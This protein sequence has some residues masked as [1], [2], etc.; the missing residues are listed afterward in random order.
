MT[1][2]ASLCLLALGLIVPVVR[3]EPVYVIEQLVVSVSSDPGGEG[4]NIGQV[5][6]A[7][8]L[9][10]LERQGEESHVRLPSGKEGWVKSSYL[11]SDEPLQGR[12]NERTSELEKAKQEAEKLRQDVSHLQAEV[13]SANA[14]AAAAT[15]AA[16]TKP[17]SPPAAPATAQPS[18]GSTPPSTPA[19]V[20]DALS[21]STTPV[22]ETVFLREPDRPGQT[23]WSLVIGVALVMLLAGFVLGWSALD[24]KIRRRYGGLRIY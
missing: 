4:E 12:L 10:L 13:S 1:V 21:G 19:S 6:S 8:R 3:A 16:T 20:S 15:T 18:S 14:R 22:R 23:P 17:T 5:K 24:R 7:D 2:R 11:T 9:E